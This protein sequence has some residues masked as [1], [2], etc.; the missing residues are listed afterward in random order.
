MQCETCVFFQ[1]A[2]TQCRR[3]APKAEGDSTVAVW[4]TV[5]AADWCGEYKAKEAARAA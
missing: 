2:T 5:A 3:H 1:A 4:P